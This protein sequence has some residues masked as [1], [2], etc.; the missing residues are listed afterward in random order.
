MENP[1]F[2]YHKRERQWWEKGTRL[3]AGAPAG[4]RPGFVGDV[5]CEGWKGCLER[6]NTLSLS[7][8]KTAL[9]LI[10]AS[11]WI[12]SSKLNC[13]RER[14]IKFVWILWH[15]LI[16]LEKSLRQEIFNLQGSAQNTQMD[17]NLKSHFLEPFHIFQSLLHPVR[18][19]C[20]DIIPQL[21]TE[22]ISAMP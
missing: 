2:I 7:I 9:W 1:Y 8:L 4:D 22:S 15:F 18:C 16:I 14:P 17:E 10:Y 5:V 20:D 21:K 13:Q 3:V 12:W 6:W 11:L 19:A